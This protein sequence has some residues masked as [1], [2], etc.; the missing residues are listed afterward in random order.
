MVTFELF[1]RPL[2]SALAG[3]TPQKL[4]FVH[5]KLKTAIKTKI[6][7][8]RFLPA[9]ISGEFEQSEVELIGWQGSGDIAS[10]AHAN[11]FV[12]VPPDRERIE[13]GEWVPV[14]LKSSF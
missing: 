9:A 1:A 5:A 7:L 4:L 10:A 14:L 12:V 2:I 13:A 11:C 8:R 6:G 3:A